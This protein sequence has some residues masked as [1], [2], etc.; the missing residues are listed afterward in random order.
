MATFPSCFLVFLLSMLRVEP[1]YMQLTGEGGRVGANFNKR[2]NAR[3]F[4][5]IYMFNVWGRLLE[6]CKKK[7]LLQHAKFNCEYAYTAILQKH[8][9]K[10]S[11]K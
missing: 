11:T 9:I 4:T 2:G 6:L 7:E 1:V 5:C 3:G 10:G 8:Y